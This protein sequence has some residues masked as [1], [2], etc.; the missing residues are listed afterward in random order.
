MSKKT[1]MI[2]MREAGMTYENI[3]KAFGIS[4]QA[5]FAAIGGDVRKRFKPITSEDCIYPNLRKWMNDNRVTRSELCR[6]FFG[7]TNPVCHHNVSKFMRGTNGGATKHTI[8]RY[9]AVTGLTYEELF[10]TDKE[11]NDD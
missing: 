4:K 7:N 9:L 2:K 6:K 8:D 10:E 5:V 3:G 11:Y 1:E